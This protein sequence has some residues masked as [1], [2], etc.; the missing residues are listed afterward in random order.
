MVL[1]RSG[2]STVG[3][4]DD[5]VPLPV[6][7]RALGGHND[8]VPLVL[9]LVFRHCDVGDVVNILLVSKRVYRQRM[10]FVP[11]IIRRWGKIGRYLR[12]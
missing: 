11:H 8:G 5:G 2:N 1:T 3:G 12:R 7:P 9:T 4:Q 10:E 6:Y